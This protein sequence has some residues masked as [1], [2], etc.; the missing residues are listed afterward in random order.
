MGGQVPLMPKRRK[1]SSRLNKG[2]RA[3]SGV[4]RTQKTAKIIQKMNPIDPTLLIGQ[5]NAQVAACSYL[6]VMILQRLDG[7]QHGFIGE[8]VAGVEADRLAIPAHAHD[9]KFVEQIFGETLKI[10]RQAKHGLAWRRAQ[11]E[12]RLILLFRFNTIREG[13]I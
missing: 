5:R 3:V 4:R 7:Q 12:Y 2:Q 10:L 13:L 11:R 1:P 6:L 9:R 8:L